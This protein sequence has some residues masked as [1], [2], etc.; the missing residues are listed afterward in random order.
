MKRLVLLFT[1]I[2]V[3]VSCNKNHECRYDEQYD[4]STKKCECLSESEM[5][6]CKTEGEYESVAQVHSK[7]AQRIKNPS[8]YKFYSHAGDTVKFYGYFY[9]A[10][11]QTDTTFFADKMSHFDKMAIG[12]RN[13]S[14][15]VDI[16]EAVFDTLNIR[17]KCFATGILQFP[18]SVEP[19]KQCF[20]MPFYFKIIDIHN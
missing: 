6:I 16:D 15:G 14:V 3:L 12:A 10:I 7:Y 19:S 1:L 4:S 5:F 2:L 11:S 8:E 13:V 9:V 18:A 17:K 20:T